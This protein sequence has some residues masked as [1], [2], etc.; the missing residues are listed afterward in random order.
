MIA[1]GE[2][3]PEKQ[4]ARVFPLLNELQTMMDDWELNNIEPPLNMS[5]IERRYPAFLLIYRFKIF[6]ES[7]PALYKEACQLEDTLISGIRPGPDGKVVSF[8]S[9]YWEK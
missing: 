9:K 8:N 3:A 4:G 1:H 7:M 6:R 2:A 5:E